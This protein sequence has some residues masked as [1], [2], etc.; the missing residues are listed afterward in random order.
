MSRNRWKILYCGE[1]VAVRNLMNKHFKAGSPC[2]LCRRAS[3]ATTWYSIKSGRTRCFKCFDA[4]VD[5]W[6]M[7]GRN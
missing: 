2:E 3:C 1:W 4:E 6:A 5:H 7:D